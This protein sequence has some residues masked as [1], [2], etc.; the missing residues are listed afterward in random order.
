MGLKVMSKWGHS[1]YKVRN[2]MIFQVTY[3]RECNEIG[4][5]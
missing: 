5:M 1:G 3:Y 2:I 4:D